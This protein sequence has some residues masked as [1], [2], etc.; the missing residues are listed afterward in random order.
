MRKKILFSLMIL[1]IF[2]LP[3]LALAEPTTSPDASSSPSS[4]ASVEPTA[5]TVLK[6]ESTG[7][8]V[9]MLQLRL[10][11]LGYFCYRPTGSYKSLTRDGV[12]KFQQQNKL[13]VDG[14]VGE[15]TFNKLFS[16]ILKRSP[17]ADTI[18]VVSGPA[19]NNKQ[20]TY[21]LAT[22][23]Q[24]VS[25]AFPVGATAT[26][27]D[28]NSGTTFSM[29]R[30]GGEN[31]AEVETVANADYTNFLKAF[32]GAATWEKRAVVVTVG[33]V[34]YAASLFGWPHDEDSVASN[35][36]EGRTCLYFSG[37]TSEVLGLPDTEHN[38][39]IKKATAK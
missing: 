13:D 32:G 4:S 26:V 22:D 33:G 17:L 1:L 14:T 3:T 28:F 35:G 31:H 2:S 39:F 6:M 12:I 7:V 37:S 20:K 5:F 18:K 30:T 11:D 23:W 29:K 34:N 25:S 24:T 15:N 21:G 16:K 8:N 10:R 36:M 9:T 27:T 19:E 38:E